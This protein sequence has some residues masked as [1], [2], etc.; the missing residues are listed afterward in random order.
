[1]PLISRVSSKDSSAVPMLLPPLDVRWVWHC[2][3]LTPASYREYCHSRFG[4]LVERPAIFDDENEEYA[5]NRCRDMWAAEYPSEPFDLQTI[6]EDE[7]EDDVVGGSSPPAGGDL[8]AVVAKY[9]ILYSV[10][11]DPF[12]AETV[13]L[14]SA[15]HRYIRFLHLCRRSADSAVR[16]VPTADTLLMWLTHQVVLLRTLRICCFDLD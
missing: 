2:H 6:P 1:M 9:Q 13:Y 12:V 16:M 15:R 4:R 10:F 11:S 3:C 7:G 14:V 8:F 5:S